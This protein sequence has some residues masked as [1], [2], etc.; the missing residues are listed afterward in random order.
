MS[1]NQAKR[2]KQ[3]ES[4]NARLKSAFEVR[5]LD[6]QILQDA[7]EKPLNP[8]NRRRCVDCAAEVRGASERRACK[9]RNPGLPSGMIRLRPT[10]S[11]HTQMI[12]SI[13]QQS[14]AGI[15]T[16][17]STLCSVVKRGR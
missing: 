2:F 14:S 13:R 15:D 16:A 1:A 5:T 9:A 17:E 12:S 11:S 7:A 4:E 6:N 8:T 10:T 3:T